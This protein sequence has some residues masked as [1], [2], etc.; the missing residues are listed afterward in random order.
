M[1]MTGSGKNRTDLEDFSFHGDKLCAGYRE[2]VDDT[3]VL[4]D[5]TTTLP[6]EKI[7]A[8]KE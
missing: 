7:K 2:R 5:F 1:G 3:L 4:K 6:A 8:D